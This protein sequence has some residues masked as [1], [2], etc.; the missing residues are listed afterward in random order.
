MTD[1]NKDV[2]KVE[3]PTPAP[4]TENKQPNEEKKDDGTVPRH[5]L[6]EV[7]E[8][9]KQAEADAAAAKQRAAEAEARIDALQKT[10]VGAT[11]SEREDKI[12]AFARKHNLDES[13]VA[14]LASLNQTENKPD[15]ATVK[16]M[17]E[18]RFTQELD[19]LMDEIPEAEKMTR[20]ERK[21]LKTRAL[22][23]EFAYTPLKTIYRD[24]MFDKRHDTK[25]TFEESRSGGRQESDNDT[26]NFGAMT[27]DQ[28][29][30]WSTK[31]LTR[32]RRR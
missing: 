22:S 13:F 31:N 16:A 10:L 12:S 14:E 17:V 28:M 8:K 19:N 7:E 18:V 20:E 5:R 24:M 32:R 30:E 26:P 21:E 11:K 4:S 1:E 27:P 15:P 23:K 6:N 29:R 2:T 3:N 25:K 9:R